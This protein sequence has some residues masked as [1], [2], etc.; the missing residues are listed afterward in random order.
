MS[1]L[2]GVSGLIILSM[3]IM[4][5]LVMDYCMIVIDK[6][7]NPLTPK[8]QIGNLVKHALE[9]V[10]NEPGMK[11]LVLKIM[12]PRQSAEQKRVLKEQ[13]RSMGGSGPAAV[14]Y[15]EPY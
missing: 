15:E 5:G 14:D 2:M 8:D 1:W 4:A 6:I 10:Q 13:L 11:S 9:M 12:D 7:I 3:T